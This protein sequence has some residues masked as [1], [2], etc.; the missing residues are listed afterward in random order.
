MIRKLALTA[1]A[2]ACLSSVPA[3]AVHAQ[4]PWVV[5]C[6]DLSGGWVCASCDAMVLQLQLRP[7]LRPVLA[8]A[9]RTMCS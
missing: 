3:P 5:G 1:F 2:A 7:E 6:V 8:V 9:I 4:D